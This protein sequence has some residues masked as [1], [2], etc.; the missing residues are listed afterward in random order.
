MIDMEVKV[1]STT[2]DY[3]KK[4]CKQ[5]EQCKL[6]DFAMI[7]DEGISITRSFWPITTSNKA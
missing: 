5:V 4:K 1:D 2:C 3:A 6:L 7:Q